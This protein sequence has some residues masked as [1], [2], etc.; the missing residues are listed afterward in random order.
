MELSVA[1]MEQHFREK[2]GAQLEKKCVYC[3]LRFDVPD[4]FYDHLV[5]KHELPPPTD[6][7]REKT[8]PVSS[9][10][11]GAL[12]VFKIEGT[13][14]NDLMQFMS[15]VKPQLDQL[16]TENVTRTGRIMQLILKVHLS[17][18]LKETKLLYLRSLMVPVYGTSLPQADFLAAVDK[19]LNT[20]FTFTASGSGWI[21]DKIVDLE[22]KHGPLLYNSGC[23]SNNQD[24][25]RVTKTVFEYLRFIDSFRFMASSLEKL[26]SY[27]P[28]EKFKILDNCF[29]DYPE[30]DR[31]LL[32]QKGYYPYSYFDDFNKFQE[33]KRNYVDPR[34][35]ETCCQNL[36]AIQ[37]LKFG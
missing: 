26:A 24:K 4:K 23:D 25:H 22:V 8:K 10:F 27:L 3:G 6:A 28:K 7:D 37:L 13:N 18:P 12:K 14:E 5:K 32:H 19:L 9:A 2:H 16:V 34:R 21:L 11:D 15:N 35:M 20:L 29:A 1:R 31:D 30:T 33:E 17:K 36:S